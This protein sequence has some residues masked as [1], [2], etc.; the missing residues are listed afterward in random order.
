MALV[1]VN[2]VFLLLAAASSFAFYVIDRTT[3]GDKIYYFSETYIKVNMHSYTEACHQLTS[4][5][6]L[7]MNEAEQFFLFESYSGS[8][9]YLI[10]HVGPLAD[11]GF[12]TFY[13]YKST[14]SNFENESAAR[15]GHFG[16]VYIDFPNNWWKVAPFMGTKLMKYI[17]VLDNPCSTYTT[18]CGRS[19]QCVFNTSSGLFYCQT[20]ATRCEDGVTCLNGG[21]CIDQADGY[22]CQ[23]PGYFTGKQCEYNVECQIA[24]PCH[25]G[26]ICYYKLVYDETLCQCTDGY[27]GE[28]CQHDVSTCLYDYESCGPFPC[29]ASLGWHYCLCSHPEL[30]LQLCVSSQLTSEC[31]DKDK[32]DIWTTELVNQLSQFVRPYVNINGSMACGCDDDVLDNNCEIDV[33]ECASSP[34]LNGGNC[35]DKTDGFECDCEHTYAPGYVGDRCQYRRGNCDPDLC[36]HGGT[37]E[38]D[39]LWS[40]GLVEICNCTSTGYTGGYC[41]TELDECESDPCLH[42]GHCVDEINAYSCN[43][44]DT[45]YVGTICDINAEH[46]PND[47]TGQPCAR[48]I[49]ECESSPCRHGSCIDELLEYRCD[50]SETGYEGTDCDIDIDECSSNLCK[51]GNC[52]DGVNYFTC[53]CFAGYDGERCDVISGNTVASQEDGQLMNAIS[54]VVTGVLL[55]VCL[56]V[57]I[58][59]VFLHR[60]HKFS[61]RSSQGHQRPPGYVEIP[62]QERLVAEVSTRLSG[63]QKYI[64]SL[65]HCY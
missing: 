34:C 51:Q 20:N 13:S 24:N 47:E 6:A 12:S 21:V 35:V 2:L 8:D 33:N 14:Y 45:G 31:W 62:L 50:C 7:V 1:L 22:V 27:Y 55:A 64:S 10:G 54:Y 29:I 19:A 53:V 4:E 46:C 56:V 57:V 16:I 17:C 58:A 18:L 39:L 28:H 59:L 42:S 48:D 38:A 49:N 25:N 32:T 30:D 11:G 26:G 15:S 52:T 41:H 40:I 9:G 5:P 65:I 60:R 43:C 37:C 63:L 44:S 23:C 61:S 36:Q 3:N